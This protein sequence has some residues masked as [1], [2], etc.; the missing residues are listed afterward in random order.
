MRLIL[1]GPDNA[2][3]TTLARRL[4]DA[5]GGEVLRYFH[6]GGRPE[7][8][9]EELNCLEDQQMHLCGGSVILDRVTAISQRVYNPDP[10]FDARRAQAWRKMQ[11]QC[12][13]VLY[14]RPSNDRLLRTQDFTWRE[15]ETDEHK[16]KIIRGQHEFVQRYD[17]LF[18]SIPCVSYDWADDVH[19]EMIYQKL[20]KAFF[21]SID[22]EM[23]FKNLMNY[24]SI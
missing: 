11:I 23:W 20:H 6:P 12:P 17:A 15:G 1:E 7:S 14:C 19:R 13:V 16:E 9:H 2:G 3:K 4:A 10:Q 24:R 22:D 5:C 21:G 18:A 8:I